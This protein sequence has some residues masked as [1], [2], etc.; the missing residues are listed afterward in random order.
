MIRTLPVPLSQVLSPQAGVRI[1]GV[2]VP[3][4]MMYPKGR[5]TMSKKDDGWKDYADA[6][7]VRL[8]FDTKKGMPAIKQLVIKEAQ[9]RK[10][11]NEQ[12]GMVK[13][14]H[15]IEIRHGK[16]SARFVCSHGMVVLNSPQAKHIKHL[17]STEKIEAMHRSLNDPANEQH[18]EHLFAMSSKNIK[19]FIAN[20]N[21]GKF[22]I[23]K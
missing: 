4:T 8:N 10:T 15:V 1:S 5:A 3:G 14:E 13:I 2:K 23:G 16:K 7:P 11:I 20:V 9:Y 17:T 22:T 19:D 18:F 6:T 21:G 12:M